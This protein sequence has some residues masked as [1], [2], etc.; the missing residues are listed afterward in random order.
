MMEISKMM[1]ENEANILKRPENVCT[2]W[3]RRKKQI[4]V[5]IVHVRLLSQSYKQW[6]V[7]TWNN[8]TNK[9]I[10]RNG[11]ALSTRQSIVLHKRWKWCAISM[12]NCI[13]RICVQNQ[14]PFNSRA[15]NGNWCWTFEQQTIMV[16]GKARPNTTPLRSHASEIEFFVVYVVHIRKSHYCEPRAFFALISKQAHK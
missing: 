11:G 12:V 7:S 15:M 16:V 1:N 9:I 2:L 5:E 14:L 13:H 3:R 8:I 10:R 4:K 6:L